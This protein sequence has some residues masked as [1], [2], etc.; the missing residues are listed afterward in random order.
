MKLLKNR[1]VAVLLAVLV[2]AG[3]TFLNTRI[4]LSEE[5]RR[6]ED[7]FYTSDS[8]SKSIYARLDSR[9]DAANGLWT[10][11]LDHDAEA[12]AELNKARSALL[13][14]Y[15]ARD[16]PDM[17]DANYVL[18]KAFDDASSALSGVTL[19]ASEADAL[20]DY[21]I[22]FAG[23]QRMIDESD[24]NDGVLT[25]MRSTYQRFPASFL[26]PLAGVKAPELFN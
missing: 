24:Y 21:V 11:L 7:G 9:L 4:K 16:I 20:H 12:A 26:A 23:A 5:C 17:Y 6:V 14:A 25:F 10:I 15:D 3:S 22:T 2:V 18:Q 13:K 1:A 19:S 8:G